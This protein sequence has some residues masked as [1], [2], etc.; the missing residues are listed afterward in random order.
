MKTF[1]LILKSLISNNACVE[2]G[3]KKR[4]YFAVI[5]FFLAMVF[6]ILP[7]FVQTMKTHGDDAFETNAY[8]L[9]QAALRF[10]EKLDEQGLKIYVKTSGGSEKFISCEDA[11]GEPAQID[12][13]HE[14]PVQNPDGSVSNQVDYKFI[15]RAEFNEDEFNAIVGDE[16][17]SLVIMYQDR[18]VIQI[19]NFS[20]KE[21]I[22]TIVCNNAAKY[23]DEGTCINDF[24]S[25]NADPT[26]RLNETFANWKLFIRDAYNF[27]RL[28]GVWQTCALMGGINVGITFF[29]GFM[30]WIL[31]RG[32][33]NP[34]RM[35]NFWHTQKMAWWAAITPSILA[36]GFGFLIPRFANILFPMLIGIR[37]MWLSMKSL[38][39]DGSGYA[40]Q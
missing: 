2:G 38:R 27:T 40:A 12:Y 26:A 1:K 35:F 36:L 13:Y 29:M 34:Y 30:I 8:G 3:H 10:N 6:A 31:T 32:K 23:L 16:T 11:S 22:G 5:M 21:K 7:L 39:P 20:N 15:Y 17:T 9:D 37:V 33:N 25:K 19:V 14:A 18:M 24:L 4:W 28:T